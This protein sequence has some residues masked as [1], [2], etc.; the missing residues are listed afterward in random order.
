MARSVPVI[1]AGVFNS[2]ILATEELARD[3]QLRAGAAGDPGARPPYG[4]RLPHP[5]RLAPPGGTGVPRPASGGRL[6]AGRGR[7]PGRGAAQPGPVA[8]PVPAALW[9]DLA[10]AGLIAGG[11]H[12]WSLAGWSAPVLAGLAGVR[13]G[14]APT[15]SRPHLGVRR[16][17]VRGRPRPSGWA[18]S[19]GTAPGPGSPWRRAGWSRWP[20][21]VCGPSA[22]CGRPATPRPP[23][24]SPIGTASEPSG[25]FVAAHL[26][27]DE[28]GVHRRRRWFHGRAAGRTV[29]HAAWSWTLRAD[30]ARR[31]RAGRP[32]GGLAR[33]RPDLVG[34]G[35]PVEFARSDVRHGPGL[36]RP[37]GRPP[38]PRPGRCSRRS[39]WPRSAAGLYLRRRATR[40]VRPRRD[41]AVAPLGVSR[42]HIPLSRKA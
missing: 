37:P 14:V 21:Q 12:R 10:E 22:A 13:A 41:A 3:V 36:P 17:P 19:S 32:G 38:R 9:I 6:G 11:S 40:A 8:R 1:A 33:D 2:G 28:T 5:R 7:E 23:H 42:A 34:D 26:T 31:A 30:A 27:A 16:R 29:G 4:G 18:G 20:S 25:L 15:G 39:P 24:P 35:T